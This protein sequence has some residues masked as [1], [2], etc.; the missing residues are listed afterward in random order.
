MTDV[1]CARC[2]KPAQGYATIGDERYCHGDQEQPTCYMREQWE[3]GR[4]SLKAMLPPELGEDLVRAV[5][6]TLNPPR[7]QRWALRISIAL[8]KIVAPAARWLIGTF[9]AKGWWV[10]G[11]LNVAWL[12]Y[13]WVVPLYGWQG[14]AR[15]LGGA[16]MGGM[17]GHTLFLTFL[18][19][20]GQRQLR[21]LP[22]VD[23]D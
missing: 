15:S 6:R 11:A 7:W 4:D 21:D 1:K 5:D 10:A 13:A 2:G 17:F 23:R 9:G 22:E 18:M 3:Q 8:A 14:M 19:K 16:W 12:T 20:R